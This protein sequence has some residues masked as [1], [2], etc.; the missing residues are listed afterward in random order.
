MLKKSSR[1]AFVTCEASLAN[2]PQPVL[3][4]GPID[5]SRRTA[6][7]GGICEYP[8]ALFI[9][10]PVCVGYSVHRFCGQCFRIH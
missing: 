10:L 4:R 8:A 6:D 1:V 5:I 3:Q 9:S 7:E 2:L